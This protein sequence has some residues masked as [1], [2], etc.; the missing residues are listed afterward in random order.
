VSIYNN[1]SKSGRGI[2]LYSIKL[3]RIFNFP[4]YKYIFL[5]SERRENIHFKR[6]RIRHPVMK[7]LFSKLL[8]NPLIP[9]N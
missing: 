4:P 1:Y 5:N 3:K 2:S 8:G 9:R 7:G 6:V